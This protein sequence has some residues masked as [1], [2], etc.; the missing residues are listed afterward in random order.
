MGYDFFVEGKARGKNLVGQLR[1]MGFV[2]DDGDIRTPQF[3]L[4][5]LVMVDEET[6]AGTQE[7]SPPTASTSW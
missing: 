3:Y 6:I 5:G 4:T 7:W 2:L 1:E